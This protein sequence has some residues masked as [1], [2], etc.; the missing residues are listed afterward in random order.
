MTPIKRY[1]A[2]NQ[3]LGDVEE[4]RRISKNSS[5]YTLINGNLFRYTFSR[6]LLICVDMGEATRIMTELHEGICGSH[7]GGRALMLRIIRGG[8]FWPT[9]KHNCMEYVRKCEQ[10]QKHADWSKAPPEVLHSINTPWP[11]LTWGIDILGMFSKG[12]RQHKFLIIVVEYFTKWIEIEPVAV[13]SGS[14]VREFI[15]KNIICRFRVPQCIILDN[16]TQFACSQVRQLC[17]AIGIKQVFSFVEHPQTNGQAEVAN[18]VI[19]R[20]VK[21]RLVASKEEWPK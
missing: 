12:V 15:W 4:A 13:I 10:C 5:R 20:G 11:F 16:W 7:I 18:K 2:D 19:L 17:D 1:L 6:P 3:L 21:R 14:R 8:F 9:M